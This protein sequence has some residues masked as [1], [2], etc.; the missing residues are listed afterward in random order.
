MLNNLLLEAFLSDS[1][2]VNLTKSFATLILTIGIGNV[3]FNSTKKVKQICKRK[4]SK[5]RSQLRFSTVFPQ[6]EKPERGSVFY[7]H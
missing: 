5:L 2:G 6:Q 7:L 3:N 4:M 1:R